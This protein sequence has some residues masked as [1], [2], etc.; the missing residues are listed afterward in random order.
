MSYQPTPFRAA[1]GLR[2]AHAQ[3]IFGRLLRREGWRALRR[4]RWE[5]PDGDFVD[6]DFAPEPAAD[7]APLV[8]LLHGLEGSARRGYA[9]NTYRALAARGVG[10]VGLNFRSCSGEV[11]RTARFY[12]SGDTG[13][14][15]FVLETLAERYPGRRLGAIGFS[16]GG[17]ALLKYLGE[18]GEAARVSAAAAVS[19]PFDLAAGARHLDRSRMGRFYT[20]TF[21]KTLREKAEAK[22][23]LLDGQVDL[24]RVRGARTFREFDDAAT[25]PLH[26][27]AD[28]DDYYARSSSARFLERIRV[29]TLLLH[30]RDDPFL[31]EEAIPWAAIRANPCLH[32]VITDEGGHVGFIGGT[33]FRPKF[34]AEEEAAR[35]LAGEL[36]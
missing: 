36:V 6:L 24:D 29:P 28:A 20:S 10:A 21:L 14:I 15:R 25:A 18:A 3:T 7:G 17:N 16:L 27:F 22:R 32:A 35:F 34:W 31:P 8:L 30:S 19:I 11:N 12:H 4:E 13:D 33:P 9:I 23:P 5:T 2:H 26:G 1:R